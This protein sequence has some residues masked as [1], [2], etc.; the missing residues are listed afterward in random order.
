[1]QEFAL[2]FY[3]YVFIDNLSLRAKIIAVDFCKTSMPVGGSDVHS[4]QLR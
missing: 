3:H 1:L 4:G 2:G